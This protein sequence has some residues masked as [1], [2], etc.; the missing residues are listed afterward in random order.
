MARAIGTRPE[1]PGEDDE[2]LRAVYASTRRDELAA[3][4]WSKAQ[5]EAFI[6]MQFDAQTRHYHSTFPAAA[7]LIICVDEGPAGRLIVSRRE[8]EIRIVDLA[9]LPEFR[10]A[11]IG[12]EL[13]SRLLAEADAARLP[14]RCHVLGTNPARAFWERAGFATLEGD[15][16]GPGNAGGQDNGGQQRDAGQQAE[17]AYLFME[18][19]CG[20]SPP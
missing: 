3:F 1:R 5:E 6:R 9:L 10:G 16:A 7:R 12:H 8:D 14:V 4:G 20:I 17:A 19:P 13:V 18:R 11:G 15:T 2:F